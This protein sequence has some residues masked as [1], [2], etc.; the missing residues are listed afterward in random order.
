[1]KI[2]ENGNEIEMDESWNENDMIIK[3]TW[4][5]NETNMK[6]N[7]NDELVFFFCPVGCFFQWDVNS[8]NVLFLNG[9]LGGILYNDS[10]VAAIFIN[11]RQSWPYAT[12]WCGLGDYSLTW[13][14]QPSI[15]YCSGGLG[16]DTGAFN[17][18]LRNH[19][20]FAYISWALP[21]TVDHQLKRGDLK[22]LEK[23]HIRSSSDWTRPL[24]CTHW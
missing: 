11:D 1:M 2:N 19:N 15:S 9:F 17:G 21:N 7:F 10:L 23:I 12:A 14:C 6:W 22:W 24:D 4:N 8:Y 16:T 3:R 5:W 20:G 18:W 13:V